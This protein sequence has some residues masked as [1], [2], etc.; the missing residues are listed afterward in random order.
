MAGVVCEFVSLSHSIT[1]SASLLQ[2][3]SSAGI[4][5]PSARAPTTT[6]GIWTGPVTVSGVNRV[7]SHHCILTLFV[8]STHFT[9]RILYI[10]M[11]QWSK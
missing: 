5:R 8:K 2:L 10:D 9:P 6:E 3:G 1:T 4:H 11:V 7:L